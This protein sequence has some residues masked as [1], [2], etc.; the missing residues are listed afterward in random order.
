MPFACETALYSARMSEMRTTRPP[1]PGANETRAVNTSLQSIERVGLPQGI[2]VDVYHRALLLSWR[3]LLLRVILTYVA[4]NALFALGYVA[5]GDCIVGARPGHLGDA[6]AFS[7]QTFATIGYG[8]L[9]PVGTAANTLVTLEAILG[10]MFQAVVTGLTFAKFARPTARVMF[11]DKLAV[12]TYDGKPVLM[13]RMGN[14]RA[15]QVVEA[16]LTLT[17]LTDEMTREGTHM[18]RLRELT[19]VRHATPIFALSWTAMH[20]IDESSPLF[21][22]SREDLVQKQTSFLATFVGTD[23]TFN[24]MVHARQFWSMD[25]VVWDHHFADILYFR[26]DGTRVF[27]YTHFHELVA[28]APPNSAPST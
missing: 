22:M 27:D 3:A 10:M 24:Q 26:E 21:G 12:T 6:F 16:R 17:V 23:D 8:V 2:W 9:S 7:V 15:N 25:D 20:E 5:C 18:R 28:D 1:V 11:T 14:Q 19:L 4:I 13:V